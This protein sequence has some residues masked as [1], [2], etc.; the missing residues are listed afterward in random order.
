MARKLNVQAGVPGLNR[1]DAYEIQIPLP[2][3]PI[4]EEIVAEIDSYQKIIDGARMVVENYK[5]RID[6]DP[7]WEMV[8]I[9]DIAEINRETINPSKVFDDWFRYV[10]ISS[11]E[12]GTGV[13][14]FDNIVKVAEAPSRARRVVK[15]DDIL[16]STVRPNL[17]AHAYLGYLPEKVIAS[18]GFA[19]LTCKT[20]IFSRYLFYML[21]DESVQAQ[22]SARMGKGSYPSINEKDVSEIKIPLPPIEKQKEIVSYLKKEEEAIAINKEL[23]ESFEKKII[24]RIAKVWGE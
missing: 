20:G 12:N 4:Q 6:I 9:S 24:V 13:V 16:L 3:L 22:M 8:E 5:P 11:V 7:E 19:V 15:K 21:F 10:D 23:I 1:N 2:A 17:Q 14:S 18:T